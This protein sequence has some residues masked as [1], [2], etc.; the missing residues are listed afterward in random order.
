ML[1][2][3]QITGFLM[4]F[5]F[6]ATAQHL[7]IDMPKHGGK[8]VALLVKRGVR[9]DTL[10]RVILD[11]AGKGQVAT[12]RLARVV[13]GALVIDSVTVY[14]L[15]VSPTE[16]P[17]LNEIKTKPGFEIR[18]STENKQ[19][20]SWASQAML[21]TAK[22]QGIAQL[23]RFYAKDDAFVKE[24]QKEQEKISKTGKI[25]S[26]SVV[27]SS[28]FAA[29][30]LSMKALVDTTFKRTYESPVFRTTSRKALLNKIDMMALNGTDMWFQILNE[31][32][33][34]YVKGG[35]YYEQFGT[36]VVTL[37]QKTPDNSVVTDLAE[38]AISICA[39][40]SW[41]KDQETMV[42]YLLNTN[43]LVNPQG[44][45]KK[46]VQMNATTVGNK[47]PDL[48]LT[49][50][51]GKVEEHNH[52]TTVLKSEELSTNR[53]LVIFYQSGCGHCEDTMNGLRKNYE[54]L[55]KKGLRIIGISADAD[56]QVF[57]N[58]ANSYP[59]KDNYCD[60]EGFKGI[61]FQQYAVLGTPTLF[62]ID[63]KGNI[64][65]KLA[66]VEELLAIVN[67]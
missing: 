33:E 37:M 28:L 45:L 34:V 23:Q 52:Q 50:H 30:Y 31:A 65:A 5:G 67:K 25:V 49:Q 48:V 26:D 36:D 43:R 61:N 20:Q 32:I 40:Y 18:N 63:K 21:Q 56:E 16:T 10:G 9:N 17:L 66:S 44:N 6:G 22:M 39:K 53:S 2:Y 51:L 19:L 13:M 58:T 47:A 7:R 11:N 8:N 62:L 4:C 15:L 41:N 1:K 14:P 64:E 57:S 46:L 59:W 35:E 55:R 3:L 29:K 38:A 54:A 60:T 27:S 24:L 42:A 12:S